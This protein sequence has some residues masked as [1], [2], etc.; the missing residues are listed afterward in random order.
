MLGNV[1]K[2]I[3]RRKLLLFLK[4]PC[5]HLQIIMRD[6]ILN[7]AGEMFLNFG[8]KSVTM[9]DISGE[10]GI[11]KKT[12]YKYFSKKTELVDASTEAVHNTINDAITKIKEKGY[13]AIEEEFAVKAIFKEMFK[14]AKTSPMF[15]LKKYY[16]ETYAKLMDREICLF[17]DCNIDNLTKGIKEGFYRENLKIDL[18]VNFYFTL[19]FGV[20]ETEMYGSEMQ[21]VMKVEYEILE[22][23]IRAIAT[24]KGLDELSKQ[25][26]TI[27]L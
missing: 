11:S 19:I 24:Q 21:E 3:K 16:P 9:D 23:H 18:M 15:Q 13:N 17:R 2:T 6:K 20:F 22:Y 10:L 8:F 12:L 7:K 4:F 25:L 27:N 1:K 14:N 5:V 26:Q